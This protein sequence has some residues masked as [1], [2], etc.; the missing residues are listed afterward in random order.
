M[1]ILL[2]IEGEQEIA[3]LIHAQEVNTVFYL[4]PFRK[5]KPARILRKV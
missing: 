2:T 1:R 3:M 5:L 4:E